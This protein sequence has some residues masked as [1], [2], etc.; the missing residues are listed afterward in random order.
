MYRVSKHFTLPAVR[1]PSLR[2][3]P[4]ALSLRDYLE[5]VAF[6]A[7]KAALGWIAWWVYRHLFPLLIL[8]YGQE[9]L[10]VYGVVVMP[11]LVRDWGPLRRAWRRVVR[12]RWEP[13]SGA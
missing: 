10:A 1:R 6:L 4:D 12:L 11:I 9:F 5:L 3:V 2:L 7:Y 13:R 8:D